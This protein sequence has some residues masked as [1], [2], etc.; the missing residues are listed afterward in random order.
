MCR[1]SIILCLD[2][3]PGSEPEGDLALSGRSDGAAPVPEGLDVPHGS[4]PEGNEGDLA[5]SIRSHGAAPVPEGQ[6]KSEAS[7]TALPGGDLL[8]DGCESQDKAPCTEL[9]A[10]REI[11][12]AAATQSLKLS[13]GPQSLKLSQQSSH[14]T[15]LVSEGAGPSMLACEEKPDAS[16]AWQ[17]GELVATPQVSQDVDQALPQGGAEEPRPST[18]QEWRA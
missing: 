13:Q 8:I 1:S 11:L 3:P 5:L 16:M 14:L 17:A 4:E 9:D 2:V 7:P 18:L 15:E 12:E 6:E 10:E